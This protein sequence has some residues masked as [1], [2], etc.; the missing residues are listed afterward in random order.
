MSTT[1]KQRPV[2]LTILDGFG[3]REDN[4]DNAIR[5]AE[6]PTF[7]KL[8]ANNPHSFL[9]ASGE[10]VGLPDGQIGNSEV[11][12]TNIG[13]G[14]VVMQELPRISKAC[15]DGTLAQNPVLLAFIDALKVSGG[16]CH[17]MGLAS[18]GGVHAHQ[19]H[20]VALAK[21]VD[22]AGV[23][24]VLHLFSDG[25]DTPP[26]SGIEFFKEIIAEL[27]KNVKIGTVCG[28]YYAMD[29]DHRWDRV[30]KAYDA[31]RYGKGPH[32][33]NA[34]DALEDQYAKDERGDEF[35]LPAVIGDY[36]GMKDGDGILSANFRADRIR[37]LLE[38]F[39]MP[40]FDGFDRGPRLSLAGVCTMTYY[41][42]SLEPYTQVLFPAEI[43]TDLLGEVVANAG[44]KQLR[45]AE[46]EKYPHVTYF[47]NG[48]QEVQ[49]E[50]EDRILVA[51]PKVA[52]YDMQPEMSSGELTDRAVE[53]IKSGKYDMIILN[54]ANPDMVG[55]T[56]ELK[57]AIKAVE[58]VDKGLGRI[59]DAIR[60]QNGVLLVTADHGNC[61]TMKDEN[62]GAPHTAHTTNEVPFIVADY[63]T[64]ITVENGRLADIAPTILQLLGLKQPA[65]MTGHSLIVPKKS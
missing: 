9:Q 19:D 62:T 64:P 13:A 25:R 45:T 5:M 7:N 24:V 49:L 61:E 37:Q 10:A 20:I 33:P 23:P 8:W 59:Y 58:A 47:F 60:E 51:S 44:M 12:H 16:T 43:L 28:R 4:A 26:K 36:K 57:A 39:V 56:G 17:L 32:F 18:K 48:G 1:K 41:S 63:D 42:D 29:R 21:I 54:F 40:V 6:L 2:M 15:K 53:A 35:T 14:R 38:A 27:P 50:G 11:G 30:E 22:A 3:W 52:T 55:H 65:A 31:I 34:I 46:T